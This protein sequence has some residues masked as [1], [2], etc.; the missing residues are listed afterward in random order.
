MITDLL[1]EVLIKPTMIPII[2]AANNDMTDNS[3][4]I[5]MTWL[6]RLAKK[7]KLSKNPFRWIPLFF[8]EYK[9]H[10]FFI[11][12]KVFYRH[13]N[14]LLNCIKKET[15][16]DFVSCLSI[17]VML[18]KMFVVNNKEYWSRKPS[19]WIRDNNTFNSRVVRRNECK[20]G[21]T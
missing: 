7:P 19:N 14:I 10:L 9:L 11:Y 12:I 15:K 21:N 5:T 18:F 16:W 4:V 20:P 17:K 8:Y 13:K 3:I 1:F 6:N 2:V